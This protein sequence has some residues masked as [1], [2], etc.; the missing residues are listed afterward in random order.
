MSYRIECY[1]KYTNVPITAT[2]F[3]VHPSSMAA[4]DGSTVEFTCTANNTQLLNY[5]VNTT[6]A[7]LAA[8]QDKGFMQLGSEQIGSQV[9]RANLSVSVSS[10]YNNTDVTCQ[11]VGNGMVV[12]SN[13]TILTVQGTDAQSLLSLYCSHFRSIIFSVWFIIYYYY[14]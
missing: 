9:I 1:C 3:L 8:V 7:T 4:V 5:F 14:Y 2:V 13:T 11:A 10:L 6:S 12:N